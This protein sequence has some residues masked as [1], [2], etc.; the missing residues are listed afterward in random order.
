[1]K[2]GIGQSARGKVKKLGKNKG[3]MC[4]GG[5]QREE[6]QRTNQ[7]AQK[8]QFHSFTRTKPHTLTIQI[9]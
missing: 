5:R 8:P 2:E 3:S 9:F 4:W 1:M 6:E 7:G